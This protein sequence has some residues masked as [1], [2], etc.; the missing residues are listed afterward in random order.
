MRE[1]LRRIERR[2]L[3]ARLLDPL[4]HRLS[5]RGADVYRVTFAE[6]SYV[7]DVVD[8]PSRAISFLADALASGGIEGDC[9]ILLS[10]TWDVDYRR[11]LT[12]SLDEWFVCE[13]V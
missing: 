12:E 11:P 9:G 2:N 3:F 4:T 10:V 8:T 7:I 1:R 6:L 5:T 13:L